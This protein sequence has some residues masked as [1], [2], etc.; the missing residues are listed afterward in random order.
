[1]A[2]RRVP[3]IP[4]QT[5]ANW[6]RIVDL[7]ARL[8]DVPA[9][10]V[11][12]SH[13]PYHSVHVSSAGR[14]NP[15]APGMRFTLSARL[16]CD[17]VMRRDGELVVEDAHRDP[18][19]C[20]NDDLEHG[21][22]FYVGYPLKWPDGRMFGTICVLDRRR[23][24]RALMFREGLRE[25]ARV[26]EADLA[27]L[28]EMERRVRL[29]RDLQAALDEMERRVADRTRE[30]EEANTALR[31]LLANLEA[32]RAEHDAGIAQQV[33]GLVMPHLGKLRARVGGD[34]TA[35]LYLRLIEEN[36]ARLTAVQGGGLA[37]L[38]EGLTPTEREVAQMVL[39]GMTTKDIARA[40]ARGMSTV[41]FHRMNIRRKLGLAGRGQGLRALLLD[42]QG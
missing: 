23:N 42:R 28:S 35:A 31:V 8:A 25:F 3:D 2:T 18:D 11:M 1:V 22:S 6:Q 20:D 39:R 19:W 15:Y 34:E 32:A 9:S 33:K 10:L 17:G 40:L 7:I 24:R 41:D 12:R 21:M 36:L 5:V 4:L 38:L 27:L 16:Y 30:L 29:E 14:G 13:P 37:A 26:I